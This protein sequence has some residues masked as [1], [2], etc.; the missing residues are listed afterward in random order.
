MK[1]IT[2][3]L[4]I[5]IML[6]GIVN[7]QSIH[8]PKNIC[9]TTNIKNGLN[10]DLP[11]SRVVDWSI[12]GTDSQTIFCPTSI[13]NVLETSPSLNN[14]GIEDNSSNLQILINDTID[15]PSPCVFYFPPG[16]YLLNS[17]IDMVQ[18]RIIRGYSSDS[19]RIISNSNTDLFRILK[20]DYGS[21]VDIVGGYNKGST[22][23]K[24]SDASSFKAGNYIQIKQK[25]IS[26]LFPQDWARSWS[27]DAIGMIV[28]IVAINDDSIYIDRP[29]RID[30]NNDDGT[31]YIKVRSIGLIENVGFE[32]FYIKANNPEMEGSSFFFK[33]TANCRICGIE[34]DFTKY[35]HVTIHQSCNIEVK[36]SYFH[37]SYSYGGGGKG[38]GVALSGQS[39]NCLIQNNVFDSLR[40]SMVTH[41]GANG[42]V[43]AYN[44][45]IH[46]LW[47]EANGDQENIP[48]DISVHGHYPFMELF[49]G[50]IVQ[51]ITSSD[52]WGPAG[53]GITFFR[54]RVEKSN[55]QLKFDSHKQ[56]ILGNELTGGNTIIQIRD[57]VKETIVHGNNEN[58]N[59]EYDSNYS[60]ILD[61]SFYLKTKPSFF[62]NNIWPSIGPE[63]QL[64]SGTIPAKIRFLQGKPVQKC[65]CGAEPVA[66]KITLQP[67]NQSGVCIGSTVNFTIEGENIVD[68]QWQILYDNGDV[69]ADLTDNLNF[70]GTQT[71]VLNILANKNLN[72]AKF[73]CK[74]S[75]EFG[76]KISEVA[77]IVI[78]SIAPV[79]DSVIADTIVEANENCEASLRDYTAE[80]LVSDNC[81]NNIAITQMPAMGT[82][83]SDENNIIK[84]IA[85]DEAGNSSEIEFNIILEDN[86]SPEIKCVDSVLINLE[87]NQNFYTVMGTE[88]DPVDISDNC[89]IASISNNINNTSGLKNEDFPIG[90]TTI[91]WTAKDNAENEK[92]CSMVVVINKATGINV[93]NRGDIKI[94]PNP[95]KSKLHIIASGSAI[96]KMIIY[97]LSGLEI[98]EIALDKENTEIDLSRFNQGLYVLRIQTEAKV[99]IFKILKD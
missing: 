14:N 74:T 69:W 78:D 62:L 59:I 70:S 35:H 90:T 42:N 11:F 2:I 1:N 8:N 34:S 67:V 5:V 40:H 97:S 37:K 19:T 4:I 44:Y 91:V 54:N 66:P 75:N 25:N 13:Y 27:E 87:Q 39:G 61:S 95:V 38:Y 51:E 79:F 45:S 68:Y 96:K 84:L 94:F 22:T 31:G 92:S 32:N 16:T 6:L 50:N 82:I 30:F 81:D 17:R 9:D 41:L 80:I 12:A 7:S 15:Y 88:F 46:P 3:T 20:Y 72:N 64:N 43:F 36:N 89:G 63:F 93:L 99:Y 26:E 85:T 53:I 56:N 73:R 57:G 48:P 23:I 18:G 47:D 21:Y 55:L 10:G 98:Q 49:E 83:I 65:S 60:N 58:G 52:W 71:T 29:L 76:E 28:K 24:V 33:N 86:T 77:Q